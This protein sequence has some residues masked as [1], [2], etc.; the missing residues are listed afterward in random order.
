MGLEQVKEGILAD[1]RAQA[2]QELDKA[3]EEAKAI[4]AR[5]EQRAAEIRAARQH[6]MQA[7]V[8]ALKRRELALAELEAK[9]LRLR[10]QKDV[11]ARVR[12]QALDRLSKLPPATN[13]QHLTTLSK[14]ANIQDARVY[15]RPEDKA[16]VERLGVK[17]AGP[18]QGSAGGLIVESAD[19]ATREDLRYDVLMEDAWRDALGEVAGALFGKV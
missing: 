5:A 6:E 7:A 15:A 4:R 8:A 10:A 13:D 11:L 12:A 2:E 16:I 17:Y 14:K 9:K 19:G 1:A 3:R 18:L